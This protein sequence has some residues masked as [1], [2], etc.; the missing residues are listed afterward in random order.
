MSFVIESTLSTLPYLK[1]EGKV[2]NRVGV[3]IRKAQVIQKGRTI[4]TPNPNIVGVKLR[5]A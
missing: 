5:K 2:P 4:P 3:K 1:R